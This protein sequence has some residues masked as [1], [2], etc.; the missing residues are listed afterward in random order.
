M[1]AGQTSATARN[2][3][4]YQAHSGQTSCDAAEAGYYVSGTAQTS[5][6]ACAAGTYSSMLG[7][8]L[9]QTLLQD[10]LCRL[11]VR[12]VPLHAVLVTIKHPPAKHPVM[13]LMQATMYLQQVNP[14][15]RHAAQVPIKHI[16]VKH[17]RCC[18]CR[19]LCFQH[20]SN[21]SNGL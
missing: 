21:Q 9:V 17:P 5:Q 19:L 13:M 8:S 15:K 2:A 18:R 6:T 1:S 11:L 14:V 4:S 16:Q 3:G 20:S 10:I 7:R 12:R